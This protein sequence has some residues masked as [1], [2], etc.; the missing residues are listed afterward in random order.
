MPNELLRS[1]KKVKGFDEQQFIELHNSG[2]AVTSIRINPKK[3]VGKILDENYKKIPW[4]YYGYYL[5][6]R[7]LFTLDPALHAGAYY[8]QEAASQFL[9]EILKQNFKADTSIYAL[10]MC[11]APGGKSTLLSSYFNNGLIVANE[12]IKSRAAI[13]EENIVKWGDDNVVVTNNDPKDF[14][15]LNGFFDLMVIDAPCSGSGLFRRDNNAINEWSTENVQLC[16]K[17]QQRIL[18]DAYNTL[19]KEGLLIY[20]T[21]SYSLEENE[22]IVDYILQ[23][24]DVENIRIELQQQWNVIETQSDK[25]KGYGYRFFPY[26]TRSEGFFVAVFKKK[27]GAYF[28]DIPTSGWVLASKKER[29]IIEEWTNQNNELAFINV[30]GKFIGVEK[31]FLNGLYFLK[32][33]LY[34]KIAGIELG[35]I[36]HTDFVPSHAL[37]LSC[38]L[39]KKI[40]LVNLNLQQAL[41]YLRKANLDIQAEQKG[42]ALACFENMPLGWMKILSNRVNN[43]Y[44]TEWRILMQ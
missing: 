6:R 11:A 35:E 43:Y 29:E 40:N 1:L 34:I 24:F 9:W 16:C 23:N 28:T 18:H 19:K 15:K 42:W 7:P 10:D 33:A 17:R 4:S 36:K 27:D 22:E 12:V 38:I 8:V 2:D 44:P 25:E 26:N 14:D 30:N 32:Q 41:Q 37:A 39:N 31:K 20:S 3:T 13:L 5:S 21:C